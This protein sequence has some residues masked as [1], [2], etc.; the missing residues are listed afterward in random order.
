M[1]ANTRVYSIHLLMEL[2]SAEA[3]RSCWVQSFCVR[4]I[5]RAFISCLVL[6]LRKFSYD[7]VGEGGVARVRVLRGV[8]RKVRSRTRATW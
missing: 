1:C 7:E 2:H 5:Q 8:G 6:G 4:S 3:L